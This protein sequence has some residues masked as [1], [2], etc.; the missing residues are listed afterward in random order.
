MMNTPAKV[1]LIFYTTKYFGIYF[2]HK[3]KFYGRNNK[4]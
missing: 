3:T 1:T 4:R 2:L